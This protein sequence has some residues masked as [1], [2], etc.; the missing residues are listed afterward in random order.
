MSVV[1][2]VFFTT[3]C[4]VSSVVIWWWLC[5]FYVFWREGEG[6]GF[7]G[8][9]FLGEEQQ[10]YRF[11]KYALRVQNALARRDF[12]A[13][14]RVGPV[15]SVIWEFFVFRPFCCYAADDLLLVGSIV[16]LLFFD[17]G[18]SYD[19]VV[20]KL[21]CSG[22]DNFLFFRAHLVESVVGLIAGGR[23]MNEPT[24]EGRGVVGTVLVLD[25]RGI[26]FFWSRVLFFNSDEDDDENA[27]DEDDDEYEVGS[28]GNNNSSATFTSDHIGHI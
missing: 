8:G 18:G 24:R 3:C 16:G 20:L 17:D 2:W 22:G 19:V 25:T 27:E 12:R 15:R 13:A 23:S 10:D 6:Q 1:V 7:L 14:S 28:E 21:F 9:L 4:F 11:A 5:I 26:Y